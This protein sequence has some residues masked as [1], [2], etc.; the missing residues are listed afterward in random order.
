LAKPGIQALGSYL[1]KDE[2]DQAL[3]DGLIDVRDY[4]RYLVGVQPVVDNLY[5]P[6]EN[7]RK[8]ATFAL[9]E[10]RD[11]SAVEMLER[12]LDDPSEEV[13]LFAAE[14]L[15]NMDSTYNR[16][17]FRLVMKIRENPTPRLH[18]LLG[19]VYYDFAENGSN[20]PGISRVYH[21]KAVKELALARKLGEDAVKIAVYEGA[22]R[23]KLGQVEEAIAIYENLREEQGDDLVILLRLA[24][25]YF[26]RRDFPKVGQIARRILELDKEGRYARVL[27]PW[28]EQ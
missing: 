25:F 19:R 4:A 2:V 24:G 5:D 3:V 1:R 10:K 22:A 11:R 16:A 13:R 14:A 20:D 21:E 27:A 6:E 18:F 8:N 9:K 26:N 7:I 12:S 23:A 17:I 15:E 28:C